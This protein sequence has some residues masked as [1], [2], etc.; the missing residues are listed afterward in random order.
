[1]SISASRIAK[2]YDQLIAVDADWAST[3]D[4]PALRNWEKW[5]KQFETDA[6]LARALLGCEPSG[7]VTDYAGRPDAT[8]DC[9]GG[10]QAVYWY[11]LAAEPAW[12]V[13]GVEI[14]GNSTGWIIPDNAPDEPEFPDVEFPDE[15][16]AEDEG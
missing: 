5:L 9:G 3:N 15:T 10:S 16:A 2:Q 6:D 7:P 11:D 12:Q 13:I 8:S 4:K 1:M 14:G